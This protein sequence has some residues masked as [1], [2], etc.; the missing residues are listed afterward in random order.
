MV[1]LELRNRFKKCQKS[2]KKPSYEFNPPVQDTL[3]N[4]EARPSAGIVGLYKLD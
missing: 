2:A 3:S 4:M 1:E